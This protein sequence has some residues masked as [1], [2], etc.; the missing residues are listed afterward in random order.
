MNKKSYILNDYHNGCSS[1]LLHSIF[2]ILLARS[3]SI[4]YSLNFY[5]QKLPLLW[6]LWIEAN[7]NLFIFPYEGGV[8]MKKKL[9]SFVLLITLLVISVGNA[10]AEKEN[11]IQPFTTN[12]NSI[13]TFISISDNNLLVDAKLYGI[14]GKTTKVTIHLYLQQY[15]DGKWHNYKYWSNTQKSVNCSIQKTLSVPKGYKYRTQAIY[16]AYAGSNKESITK[17][18]NEVNY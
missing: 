10:Y 13:K 5:V 3:K 8:S 14:A 7:A 18:S 11:V 12:H 2:S 6:L 4:Q 9:I 1:F 15:Y 16:Y 17:Y